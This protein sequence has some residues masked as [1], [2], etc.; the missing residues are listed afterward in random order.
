[1]IIKI[2]AD[3]ALVAEVATKLYGDIETDWPARELAAY[4]ADFMDHEDE[5]SFL[6]GTGPWYG[7]MDYDS[8]KW[9]TVR[10]EDTWAQVMEVVNDGGDPNEVVEPLSAY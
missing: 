4:V 7:D 1:M 3:P 9:L 8:G 10:D 2:L 5:V 6:S